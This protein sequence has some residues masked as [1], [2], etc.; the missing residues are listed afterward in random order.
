MF[1]FYTFLLISLASVVPL[2]DFDGSG[3][4]KTFTSNVI[5]LTF[6]NQK[7]ICRNRSMNSFL[8]MNEERWF[9]I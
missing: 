2:G 5:L 9:L 6:A 7:Q 4:P 3:F 8:Y 1:I